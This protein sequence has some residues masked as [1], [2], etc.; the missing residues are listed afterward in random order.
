M[1]FGDHFAKI[2]KPIYRADDPDQKIHWGRWFRAEVV[3]WVTVVPLL[4]VLGLLFGDL[5]AAII[6][7]ALAIVFLVVYLTWRRRR[8]RRLT[9]SPTT[10]PEQDR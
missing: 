8:N 5:A 3:G 10:W 1:S 2:D 4:I 7:G 9:G 6:V